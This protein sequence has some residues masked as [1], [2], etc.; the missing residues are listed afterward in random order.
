MVFEQLFRV[1]WIERK[2]HAFVLGFVYT[3]LG[4]ISARLI[5]G[6]YVGL[7]SLGFTT[8]LLI[9]SLNALL[10]LEE[11]LEIREMRS[12]RLLPPFF[13]FGLFSL[14]VLFQNNGSFT[15]PIYIL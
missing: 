1:T 8:I 13:F 11:N 6:E 10:R 9:P 14:L 2:G 4:I 15:N 3:I 12:C 5:F 7:M